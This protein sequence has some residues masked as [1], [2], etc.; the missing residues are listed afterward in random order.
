M[1]IRKTNS[2][3]SRTELTLPPSKT[4]AKGS[5]LT[6]SS[7]DPGP[8]RPKPATETPSAARRR[9]EFETGASRTR[10]RR[11]SDVQTE[12]VR[13]PE[14]SGAK[15][16]TN[17]DIRKW[18]LEKVGTIPE[19]DKK[20][21]AQGVPMEERARRAVAIRHDA[22]LE[23]R[24]MMKNPLEVL[25]L[26]A[27]DLFT[28]GNINGPSFNQLVK[29]AED[30]GLRGDDV[31]KELIGSSNRTNQTVNQHLLGNTSGS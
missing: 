14:A 23:A 30:K 5:P 24:K 25:M 2:L 12:R 22:R 13:G 26:R 3:P 16:T 18:Y 17:S 1:K 27:R 6:R 9:D 4:P 10:P 8:S 19:L 28:Y 20:W 21:A 11:P 7:S 15:P 29:K 31:F